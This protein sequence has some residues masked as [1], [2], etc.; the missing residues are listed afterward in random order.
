MTTSQSEI[1]QFQ[2]LEKARYVHHSDVLFDS[3]VIRRSDELAEK[4]LFALAELLVEK[5]EYGNIWFSLSS[6]YELLA[7]EEPATRVELLSRFRKLYMRFGERVRFI[8]PGNFSSVVAEWSADGSFTYAMAKNIDSE[9][10][11][12][13]AAGDLVGSLKLA[14][15]DWM[16]QKAK[17]RAAYNERVAGFKRYYK[18]SSEF[19]EAFRSYLLRYNTKHALEQ[20]EGVAQTL[21]VEFAKQPPEAI[22]KAKE[23]HKRYPCTW[24]YALLSRLADYSATL[25]EGQRRA[26]FPNSGNLLKAHAN[27]FV[28]AYI[29]ASG[30]K[31]GML[32]TNDHALIDKANF[33]YDAE[34]SLIRIQAFTVYDTLIAFNPPNGGVRDRSREIP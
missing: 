12:A 18:E 19:R 4:R 24:T 29:V 20:C 30:G 17:L 7:P 6:I 31:C 13:I 1:K 27:D 10:L 3:N 34:P 22:A 25:T 21:L 26:D 2:K 5:P 15:E 28:D 14:R 32:I 33:L 23:N 8:G 16:A 11:A 9:V